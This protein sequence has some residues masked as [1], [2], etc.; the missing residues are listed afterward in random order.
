MPI[1]KNNGA[2]LYSSE[3]DHLSRINETLDSLPN[4][5]GKKLNIHI[6]SREMKT[7]IHTKIQQM[8]I[9]HKSQKVDISVDRK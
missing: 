1:I 9:I 7:Y 5:G 6:K 2:R 8:N 3:V 4:S